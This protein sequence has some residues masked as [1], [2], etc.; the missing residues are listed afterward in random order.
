MLDAALLT[1]RA[2]EGDGGGGPH[3]FCVSAC[4]STTPP[5]PYLFRTY[6]HAPGRPS[7]YPGFAGARAWE[8]T[9][10]PVYNGI[11]LSGECDGP[12]GI[13]RT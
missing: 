1:R 13:Y 9:S 8:V 6:T 3:V 7:R 2:Q 10:C 5:L 4:V 11:F 12:L